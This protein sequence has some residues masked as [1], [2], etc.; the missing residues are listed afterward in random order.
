MTRKECLDKAAGCVLQDRASQ[1]GGPEDSFGMI[2]NFWSVYLGRKVYPA[3][4]AAMM[5]LL[6]VARLR[7][8]PGRDDS[9]VDLAGY[10]ACGAECRQKFETEMKKTVEDA[11]E[12]F[13]HLKPRAEGGKELFPSGTPVEVKSGS[14]WIVAK[15]LGPDGCGFHY[16]RMPD[17][18]LELLPQ[19][20]IRAGKPPQAEGCES[21]IVLP[22]PPQNPAGEDLAGT[23]G[24]EEV[25]G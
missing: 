2:A 23:A 4:V 5:A 15:Y 19:G 13:P 8:N 20:M 7:A 24:E 6:K 9:W 3:D 21:L 11:F 10:A 1:Y 14:R 17:G 12:T 18:A 22:D 25:H 16:V